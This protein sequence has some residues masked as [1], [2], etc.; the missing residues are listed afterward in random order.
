MLGPV[1]G[2]QDSRDATS[3]FSG[4]LYLNPVEK[5]GPNV[6]PLLSG[7]LPLGY[8]PASTGTTITL[9]IYRLVLRSQMLSIPP[10]RQLS[11]PSEGM[12]AVA[13]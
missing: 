1:P 13:P 11:L 8:E 3:R 2:W 5:V 12:D 10:F 7:F 9:N 4:S 6:T